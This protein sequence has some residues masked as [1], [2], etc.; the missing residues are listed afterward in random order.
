LYFVNEHREILAGAQA[1]RADGLE[2]QARHFPEPALIAGAN[3]VAL[4][5]T[6]ALLDASVR[7]EVEDQL[8]E[9]AP[10]STFTTGWR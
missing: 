3:L 8:P 4:L 5:A 9:R 6:V 10:S 1:A 2:T 7:A